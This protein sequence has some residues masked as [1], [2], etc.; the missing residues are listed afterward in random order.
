[1]KSILRSIIL[2]FLVLCFLEACHTHQTESLLDQFS[3]S[4]SLSVS[5]TCH[6][7]EDS[8]ALVEGILCED[9]N[10]IIYDFHSGCCYTLFDKNSG[11]YITRFGIIGQGPT[12]IPSP[13]LAKYD[14][15][16]VQLSKLIVIKNSTFIDADT[17]QSCYSW[18]LIIENQI[19]VKSNITLDRYS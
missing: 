4:E 12:E 10:V 8:V 9:E 18:L 13:C 14:I 1:M 3:I 7:D 17:Y 6:I 16:D 11:N 15:P 19:S 5:E 2:L